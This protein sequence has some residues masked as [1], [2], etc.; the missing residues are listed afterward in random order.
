[1]KFC[2][3]FLL[4]LTNAILFGQAKGATP[5]INS[6]EHILNNKIQSTSAFVVGISDYQDKNIP[7]LKY[8][9]K[10]AEAFAN[11]LRSNAGGKLDNEHMKVLINQQATMAQLAIAL[12]W[13]IENAKEND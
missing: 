13:M 11:Y 9:D 2:L 4:V 6:K 12:D 7:D 5:S 1:M 10:D 3:L 8:A